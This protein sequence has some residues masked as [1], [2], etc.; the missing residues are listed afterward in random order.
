MAFSST[1]NV[2]LPDPVQLSESLA[3][4]AERSRRLV[5]EF[6]TRSPELSPLGMSDPAG[7]GSAFQAFTS[8]VI[9][10]PAALAQAHTELWNEQMLLWQR[11]S[12]RMFGL[13]G[14]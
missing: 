3:R 4:V 11:T 14:N 12:H 2:Q 5:V 8:K 13:V 9:A 7:V 10:N 1:P 6:M